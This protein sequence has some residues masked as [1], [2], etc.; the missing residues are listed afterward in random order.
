MFQQ[1]NKWVE[2]SEKEEKSRGYKFDAPLNCKNIRGS[3]LPGLE[4]PPLHYIYQ[5]NQWRSV[6]LHL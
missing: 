4:S 6:T 1:N 2:T 5:D 3:Q